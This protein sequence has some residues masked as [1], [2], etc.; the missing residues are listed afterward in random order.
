MKTD[1]SP[2]LLVIDH[3]GSG[4]AQRQIVAIANGLVNLGLKVHLVN[5]YPQY[6]HH[7]NSIDKRILVHDLNKKGKLGVGVIISMI[8]LMRKYH[9]QSALAF[10]DTPAFYLEIASLFCNGGIKIFFS[11]RSAIEL[12]PKGVLSGLKKKLHK[13]NSHITS[14]SIVQTEILQN[15]YGDSKVSYVP[16]IMSDELFK[17]P[18][19][20]NKFESKTFIVLSHTRPFKNFEYVA[21]AL[22]LYKKNYRTSPPVVQWYGELYPSKE[23]DNIKTLLSENK[24]EDN[25]IF[26]GAV[27]NV[28]E[29]INDAYFLIHAS[30]FESSA[31]A[32]AEALTSATPVIVGNIP[33]HKAMIEQSSAGYLVDLK[34]PLELTK[35]I[36][37]AENLSETDYSSLSQ[38]ARD[39]ACLNHKSEYVIAKYN[40]LLS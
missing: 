25:I 17:L 6:T 26:Y 16:N 32:V 12:K 5:Y 15:Y 3:F 14:N 2:I 18:L 1:N 37:S 13:L 40:N 8:R 19:K 28:K 9:Y 38:K 36:K 4:G 20:G 39:Y 29:L 22:V 21:Q 10:L 31:N 7:R 30:L 27:N 24:L 34:D 35:A 33:E 23:L 11:E